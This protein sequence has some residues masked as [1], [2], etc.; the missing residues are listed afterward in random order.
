M[1]HWLALGVLVG[2]VGTSGYY[3]RL[4]RIGSETIAR[5][6]EGGLL[7]AARMVGAFFLFGPIIA[8]AAAPR[9]MTWASF[10][11]PEPVRWFGVIAGLLTIPMVAWVLRSL[12]HNVS[13]TVLTKRDHA[14]VTTGPYRWLRHPLYTTAMV[15]FLSLGLVL[16][17]WFVLGMA[18]VSA[19]FIRLVVIPAEERQLIAKFGDR[20]RA[21]MLRTG[22]LLPKR[23]GGM[24]LIV[25]L[26][27][28]PQAS[29]MSGERVAWNQPFQ[30]F[31]LI[32]NIYYVGAKGVSA[33][34]I[35]TPAGSVLLDGGLPETAPQIA[36]NITDLGFRL[37]DVKYLLNSHAHFDHA[38]GLAELKRLSGAMM[39]ASDRDAPALRSGSQDMPA[40]VVDRVIRDGE[41][42]RLGDTTLTALVTPGHTK[43]CTTWTMTTTESGRVYSVIFYCSTSVVD[44]LVGNTQYPEIVADYERTFSRLRTLSSDVFLGPHPTFFDMETK[45]KKMND[46][47]PNPFVDP[48]E[49]GRSVAQSER[50][51]R[52]ELRKQQL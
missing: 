11:L 15:L 52:L 34:L 38:G 31:Q 35:T 46:G 25:A 43:G 1:F 44:R 28:L 23:T 16:A 29:Q 24:P 41:T 48:T 42:L 12:G 22:R 8:Y 4:A 33:F 36:K 10:S 19:L 27:A 2:A 9:A 5:R 26:A 30:P 7:L 45:R 21:H 40:V 6:R 3:R 13:E 39:V 51:F 32:G 17:S 14:L 47:A 20:Y 50:Q 18:A 37:G 49:L